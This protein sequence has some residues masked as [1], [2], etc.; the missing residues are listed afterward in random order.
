MLTN[1]PNYS[2]LVKVL[3]E[4]GGWAGVVVVV[5]VMVVRGGFHLHNFVI[6][7]LTC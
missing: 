5:V 1:S 4:R 7:D 3:G 2:L 6:L